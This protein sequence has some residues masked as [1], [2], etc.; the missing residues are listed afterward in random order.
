M[1]VSAITQVINLM[2]TGEKHKLRLGEDRFDLELPAG[3]PALIKIGNTQIE[4]TAAGDVNIEAV[5]INIKGKAK[6]A[7]EAPTIEMKAQ[8]QLNLD[9]VGATYLKGTV[10]EVN[11]KGTAIIKAMSVMIN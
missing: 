10:V 8:A 3:K 2:L 4:V 1:S 7:I 9:C 11:G 6:V 5:N